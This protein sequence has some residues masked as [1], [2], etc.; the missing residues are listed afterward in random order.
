MNTRISFHFNVQRP[1]DYAARLL[2][3]VYA[4]HVGKAHK[5]LVVV[6]AAD[7][8]ALSEL[9]WTQEA[10]GFLAHALLLT[11]PAAPNLEG[12]AAEGTQTNDAL[13]PQSPVVLLADTAAQGLWRGATHAAPYPTA[14]VEGAKTQYFQAF[15]QT[16]SLLVNVG[17]AL[18]PAY[19]ASVAQ[20]E[21]VVE[22]VG[23][24]EAIK[25]A[26]RGRWRFYTELGAVIEKFDAKN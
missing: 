5:A 13:L 14:L 26:A 24:D 8:A 4:A 12:A 19:L 11:A 17:A 10:E 6:P 3:K 2:R 23:A 25:Q 20:F 22:L 16:F 21:R 7:A 15:G 18:P 1:L 9:L